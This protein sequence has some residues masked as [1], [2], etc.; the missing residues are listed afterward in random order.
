MVRDVPKSGTRCSE[1]DMGRVVPVS[2]GF[3]TTTETFSKTIS[4][5]LATT[6]CR[7]RAGWLPALTKSYRNPPFLPATLNKDDDFKKNLGVTKAYVRWCIYYGEKKICND[8]TH[9]YEFGK[10]YWW[11][12]IHFKRWC[13]MSQKVVRGVPNK[14]WDESSRYQT[15]LARRLKLLVKR[16]PYH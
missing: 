8:K 10:T 13:E 3:G 7:P 2:N 11:I 15:V 4:I 5:P 9:R 16:Y 12:K 6:G 1:Q 14:I